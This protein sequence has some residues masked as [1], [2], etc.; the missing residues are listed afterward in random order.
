MPRA[1]PERSAAPGSCKV[2]APL[3]APP[4]IF[5]RD[6]FLEADEPATVSLFDRAYL[7]G[8]SLF[9]S[10]R[11][12]AGAPVGLGRHLARL[13]ATAGELGLAC[14]SAAAIEPIVR[15]ACDRFV[16]E[17]GY[18]RITLSRGEM[19]PRAAGLGLTGL[20]A[21]VLSVVVRELGTPAFPAPTEVAP[22]TL[23]AVPAACQ[24]PGWKLGSYALRVAM[25]REVEARGHGEGLVLG[26]DGAVVSGV[27][28]NLF[29]A[30][31]DLLVTPAL[32]SGCRPGV[33]RELL[34]ERLRAAGAPVE[35]R[36]V[37][38]EDLRAADGA[39]FTSSVTPLL[40]VSRF[41][42][43][44]LAPDHPCVARARAALLEA[45]A[46]ERGPA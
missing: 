46:Q 5:L 23:R 36:A 30:R 40:P 20:A 33:T 45:I 1:G 13:E 8:D 44:A 39:L 4:V 28:S 14:P 25:R 17:Y 7:L 29:L 24:P 18:L 38:L 42:S 27:S 15:T 35:E 22:V 19:P 34:L 10:L 16:S 26:L 12:Y 11:V 2:P 21:P 9:A 41:E 43:R 6:R 32:S 37:A 3:S 31:G